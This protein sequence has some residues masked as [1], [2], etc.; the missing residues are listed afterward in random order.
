MK[1]SKAIK[2]GNVAKKLP[3]VAGVAAV[4]TL[5]TMA[6][7]GTIKTVAHV[8]EGSTADKVIDF[9]SDVATTTACL[10]IL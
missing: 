10:L 8:K 4:A 1:V 2:L 5:A 6:V 3:M 7:G 9:V